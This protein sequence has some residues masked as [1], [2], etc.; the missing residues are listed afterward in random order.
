MRPLVLLSLLS[1]SACAPT[2]EDFPEKFAASWC[3]RTEECN[4]G[5]FEDVYD[6]DMQECEST[7][8]DV[9]DRLVAECDFDVTKARACLESVR[10]DTCGDLQDGGDSCGEVY[11]CDLGDIFQSR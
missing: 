5:T 3:E 7:W 10:N 4:R 1:L 6:S 11:S 9:F 2:A 8:Q